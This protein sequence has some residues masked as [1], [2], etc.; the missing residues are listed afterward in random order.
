[1]K[2]SHRKIIEVVRSVF[3]EPIPIRLAMGGK[4][5]SIHVTIDGVDHRM[6][7]ASSPRVPDH[8]VNGVRQNAMKLKRR[9]Q[10]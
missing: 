7:A 5:L 10:K 8:Q 6:I 9:L 4:H 3:P 1:M 2:K